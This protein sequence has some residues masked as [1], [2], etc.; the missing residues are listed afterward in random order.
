MI[1][2]LTPYTVRSKCPVC[3]ADLLPNMYS[4][5]AQRITELLEYRCRNQGAGCQV[6]LLKQDL[7]RHE[8]ACNYTE[9]VQCP[10][11]CRAVA[12]FHIHRHITTCRGIHANRFSVGKPVCVT[13]TCGT[14]SS[15]I[16]TQ[17]YEP[18]GQC[19]QT[20]KF[21]LVGTKVEEKA[22]FLVK[23]LSEDRSRKYALAMEV[24]N[25]SETYSRSFLGETVQ[26]GVDVEKAVE[27]GNTLELS[28]KVME[29]IC[30]RDTTT[31]YRNFEV[32]VKFNI[33][34]QITQ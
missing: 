8:L 2:I 24:S 25:K 15:L 33:M 18:E 34:K 1:L 11:G 3:L 16:K 14:F 30:E 21:F 13:L 22:V 17:M 5:F 29:R 19:G 28:A 12:R 26:V 7:L 6:A 10:G 32:V 20:E 9:K 23:L 31:V 4:Q 27:E